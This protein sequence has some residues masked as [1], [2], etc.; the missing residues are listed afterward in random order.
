M[1]GDWSSSSGR[2]FVFVKTLAWFPN[3]LQ[4]VARFTNINNN[5]HG[6]ETKNLL[7][8]PSFGET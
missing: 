2:E 3:P 5:P 6:N 1:F 4:S 8:H 7:I